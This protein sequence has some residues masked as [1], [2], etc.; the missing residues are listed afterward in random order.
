[1]AMEALDLKCIVEAIIFAAGR[2]VKFE[3]IQETL[4][5]TPK[6]NIEEAIEIL[7]KEYSG[8]G[9][10]IMLMEVA[11]GYQFSTIPE[12]IDWL[13]KFFISQRKYKFTKASLETLA[14]IAYKQPAMRIEIESIRGVNVGEV[15][16]NLLEKGLIKIVGRKAL[17][18]RPLLYGTT[19]RFLMHFGLRDLSDLPSLEEFE[20]KLSEI[21]INREIDEMEEMSESSQN[22]E[23]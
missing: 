18:G 17:P 12:H 11:G 1:M 9:K 16:H 2:P 7:E 15:L 21:D 6:K 8:N 20:K 10:G 14:I 3:E 22:K 13:K 23:T 19:D 5:D 4:G